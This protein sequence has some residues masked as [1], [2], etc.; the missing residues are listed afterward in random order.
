MF[1]LDKAKIAWLNYFNAIGGSQEEKVA[2]IE[3][4]VE[5]PGIIEEIERL[6]ELLGEYQVKAFKPLPIK[7]KDKDS[8]DIVV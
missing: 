5:L 1:N 2:C 6:R 4:A 3:A 8:L 7:N